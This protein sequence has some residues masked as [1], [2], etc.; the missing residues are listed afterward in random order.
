[1]LT[2]A[3]SFGIIIERA[4]EGA[5]L[6]P[7]KLNNEKDPKIPMRNRKNGKNPEMDKSRNSEK[8]AVKNEREKL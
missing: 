7:W 6:E 3:F 1:M 2:F 8:L 4:N 5:Q